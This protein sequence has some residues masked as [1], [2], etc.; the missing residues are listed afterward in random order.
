MNNTSQYASICVH[1]E[2]EKSP[3]KRFSQRNKTILVA[4]EKDVDRTLSPLSEDS[5]GSIII[6]AARRQLERRR[7][8]REGYNTEHLNNLLLIISLITGKPLETKVWKEATKVYS[9]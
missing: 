6:E 8:P 1:N 4:L 3:D 7:P 5:E 2:K 9:G